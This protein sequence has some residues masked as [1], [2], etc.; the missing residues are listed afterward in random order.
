MNASFNGLTGLAADHVWAY[1]L[2]RDGLSYFDGQ[3]W[4]GVDTGMI[5][6]QFHT[7][8]AASRTDG[9][10]TTSTGL[11]RWDGNGWF[12][13]SSDGFAGANDFWGRSSSDVWAA[14]NGG[15]VS[16]FDGDKWSYVQTATTRDFNK[17]SGTADTLWMAGDGVM[18]S[19][20][21]Q[22][23]NLNLSS[24][25][26]EFTALW[27]DGA[28][29][30]WASTVQGKTWRMTGGEWAE[31]PQATTFIDI[32]GPGPRPWGLLLGGIARW[33]GNEWVRDPTD[34]PLIKALWVAP[35]GDTFVAGTAGTIMR[36]KGTR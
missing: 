10:A 30:G 6:R 23:W 8:W 16:H 36:R 19:R 11:M 18:A 28:G 1:G 2:G 14:G 32:E 26:L 25:L 12:A 31:W 5:G 3:T 29:G 7:V 15:R 24:P 27:L 34:L 21:G 13:V 20:V 33:N 35:N 4:R 9:W 22:A 17:V